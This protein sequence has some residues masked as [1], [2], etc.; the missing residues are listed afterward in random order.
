MVVFMGNADMDYL[1][2]LT[3]V[4]TASLIWPGNEGQ[5]AGDRY[6]FWARRIDANGK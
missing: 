2:L 5:Y 1:P 3:N 6:E 4:K